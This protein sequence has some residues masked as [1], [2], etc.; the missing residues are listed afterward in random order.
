M[1]FTG[2]VVVRLQHKVRP[3]HP[4]LCGDLVHGHHR[5]LP[6]L[7][8]EHERI[9]YAIAFVQYEVTLRGEIFCQD[10]MRGGEF[11]RFGISKLAFKLKFYRCWR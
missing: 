3:V 10:R 6:L 8:F 7:F 2:N 1:R 4:F 9:Y 11:F 5:G